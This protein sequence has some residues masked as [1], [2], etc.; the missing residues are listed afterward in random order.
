MKI[1]YEF[2]YNHIRGAQGHEGAN[3]HGVQRDPWE[4]RG[5]RV[6]EGCRWPQR[7]ECKGVPEVW[8]CHKSAQ[9]RARRCSAM[10]TG[11]MRAQGQ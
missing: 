2:D 7:G 11:T 4:A 6:R 8:R 5:T 10:G 1:L 9:G 3:G